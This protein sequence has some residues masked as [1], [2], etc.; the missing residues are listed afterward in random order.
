MRLARVGNAA[1]RPG[2]FGQHRRLQHCGTHHATMMGDNLE[3]ATI[4][5]AISRASRCGGQPGFLFL[6]GDQAL[7][8][9]SSHFGF[10]VQSLLVSTCFVARLCIKR[11]QTSSGAGHR[12]RG[13][14]RKGT[15]GNSREKQRERE[16]E[17]GDRGR[18]GR[19]RKARQTQRTPST[20]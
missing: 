16:R 2:R 8:W 11:A 12:R 6:E 1:T 10:Q 9:E 5:K 13:E 14:S 19:E 15:G 4:W 18:G 3:G 17:G 7:R 20:G